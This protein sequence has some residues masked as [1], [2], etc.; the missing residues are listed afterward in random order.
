MTAE[1]D[2]TPALDDP[3][4]DGDA[5]VLLVEDNADDAILLRRALRKSGL[6]LRLE[7]VNHGDAA[8]DY[9][10]NAG[11]YADRRRHPRPQLVLLDVK[12]PRRSGH[13]VLEW[14]RQ[15]PALDAM[16]VI[17]LTSSGEE[18]DVRRAYALRASS[19]LRKP[20]TFDGLVA[21]LRLIHAYWI[22]ANV[23]PTRQEHRA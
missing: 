2:T 17:V 19:Y 5:L 23:A 7:V 11:A 4:E 16:P 1:P 9:L 8:V 13:E 6:R 21:L 18:D 3:D 22:D 12:L 20:L 14:V 10:G 15:Q